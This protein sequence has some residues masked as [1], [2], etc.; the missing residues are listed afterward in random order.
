MKQLDL[1]LDGIPMSEWYPRGSN[2]K[3]EWMGFWSLAS[4]PNPGVRGFFVPTSYIGKPYQGGSVFKQNLNYIKWSIQ[5][6]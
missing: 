4:D 6:K 1:F 2:S 3:I 5:Q